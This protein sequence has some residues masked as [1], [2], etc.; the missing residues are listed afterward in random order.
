[1]EYSDADAAA[2]A[3][4]NLNGYKIEGRELRVDF[5]KRSDEDTGT[6]SN[7]AQT[8]AAANTAAS[9]AGITANG[10]G[11]LP[12]GTELPP[13]VTCADS[14]S[15]TLSTLPPPQLLDILSQM[16]G[17]VTGDPTKA[18]DLLRAA[19]QLSYAIFQALLLMGLVDSAHI[20]QVVQAA[21]TG[22]DLSA[23]GLSRN[24]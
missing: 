24:D 19:P 5:S 3:V 4:R 21:A 12:A 13:G 1:V 23:L 18:T 14:I 17:L 10:I 16:K 9:S 8:S 11:P 6:S 2:S 20:A 15:K 22:G 7:Q